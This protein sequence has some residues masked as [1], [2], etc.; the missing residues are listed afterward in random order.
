M[1]GELL[2]QFT[3][4]D[5]FRETSCGYDAVNQSA[6]YLTSNGASRGLSFQTLASRF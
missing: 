6:V 1:A 3:A 2:T 5:L 4:T